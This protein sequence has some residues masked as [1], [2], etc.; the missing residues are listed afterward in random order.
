VILKDC[1]YPFEARYP[2][3]AH[4]PLKQDIEGLHKI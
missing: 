3:T 2:K 4:I 1:I